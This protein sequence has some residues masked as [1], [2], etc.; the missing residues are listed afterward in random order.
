[1]RLLGR[2]QAPG[3]RALGCP[4]FLLVDGE[5][6]Q[7][8]YVIFHAV[9][10]T[11]VQAC[12]GWRL[13]DARIFWPWCRVNVQVSELREVIGTQRKARAAAHAGA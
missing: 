1:M 4:V 7:H 5:H 12:G 9:N 13:G 8:Q 10:H 2:Q 11:V 6:Q 3:C